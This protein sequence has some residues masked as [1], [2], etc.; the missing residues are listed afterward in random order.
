MGIACWWSRAACVV[1]TGLVRLFSRFGPALPRR[2]LPCRYCGAIESQGDNFSLSNWASLGLNSRLMARQEIVD[3]AIALVAILIAW[4]WI[5]FVAPAI[6]RGFGVPMISGWRLS[7]RNQHLNRLDYVWGCGVFAVG[8]G[9]FLFLTLRQCLYW[10]LV[11]GRIPS[12]REPYVALR[13]II[14]LGAGWPFGF[15]TAPLRQMSFPL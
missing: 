9:L 8:V 10:E 14:C 15:F 1:P 4:V 7:R 3:L 12:L 13:L 11:C 5:S 6:A 2:A